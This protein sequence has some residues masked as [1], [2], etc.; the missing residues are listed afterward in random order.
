MASKPR[1]TF[2]NLPVKDL[3]AS[4]AFF[5]KLGFE[6]D[7]KFTDDSAT[8]MIVSEQAY[9]MLLVE[10]RFADFAKK[11]VADARTTTEVMIAV[12]AESR[13]GVDEFADAALAAGGSP[14]L[15]PMD[16]GFMY[17]RSFYDLDG[18]HWEVMWMSAEAVEQGPS[19]MAGTA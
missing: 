16:H 13:E 4:V 8:C 14:A 18:H 11:P 6:F 15:E 1:L 2:I 7:P 19:D 3:D 12:S 9:V 10:P 5:R 17:G